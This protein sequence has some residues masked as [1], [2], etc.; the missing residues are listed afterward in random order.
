MLSLRNRFGIPGM[1]AVIAL[2]FAMLGGAYAASNGSSGKGATA[3]AKKSLKGPRGPRGP[4]GATGAA[5]PAGSAGA[6]GSTGAAGAAGQDGGPGTAGQD[7]ANVASIS[8]EGTEEP[9]EEP[10]EERGGVEFKSAGSTT[11]ACNGAD[12]SPWAAGGTLPSG[13][14]ETGFWSTWFTPLETEAVVETESGKT[15]AKVI[16]ANGGGVYPTFSFNVPL[17]AAPQVAL[18]P[19]APEP[20]PQPENCPGTSEEPQAASGWLCVYAD[21]LGNVSVPG[22]FGFARKVGGILFVTPTELGAEV[23]AFGTWA[24][25]G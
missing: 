12:G 15:K 19:P 16:P 23:F 4:K 22:T 7:G 25:T 2:V 11:Y 10:C 24:V 3:S 14:T 6:K 5:G 1:I 9:E 13:S 20:N 18:V 17:E 8:F 21:A